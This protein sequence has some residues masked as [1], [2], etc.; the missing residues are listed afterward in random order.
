M[1]RFHHFFLNPVSSLYFGPPGSFNAGEDHVGESW[2]PPPISSF[3]GIIRTKLLQE[4]GIFSPRKKVADLVGT[5]DM[6]P[7]GWQ[8]TGP[9]PAR[10]TPNKQ[11]EIWL[12]VPAFLLP[13]MDRH[14]TSPLFS[15]PCSPEADGTM[16]MDKAMCLDTS[17]KNE[18]TDRFLSLAG[19]PGMAE[20]KPMQ[21]WLSAQNLLWALNPENSQL[22]WE[23]HGCTPYLPPFVF[24]EVKSGL[25]REKETNNSILTITGRAKESMLYFLKRLRFA[26]LSGLTGCL[27]LPDA[28]PTS[29]GAAL[30]HGTLPAGSKGGVVGFEEVKTKDDNWE[31]IINGEHL[32]QAR[33]QD[34]SPKQKRNMV[35]ITLISPGR[36][37][38]FQ[39]ISAKLKLTGP[40]SLKIISLVGHAPIYLGGYNIVKK[41]PRQAIPWYPAGT[42]VLAQLSGGSDG[43]RINYLKAL[44]YSCRLAPEESRPFGYGH[45]V[46]TAPFYSGGLHA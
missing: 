16:L 36:W 34:D 21:G 2:F 40:V 7:Q 11:F 35:W 45:I 12:P 26:P 5:P 15:R 33:G 42:S 19:K 38:T 1:S 27:E 13:P 18:E 25:A 9:F 4:I 22:Q 44:N 6:L 3:Q 41:L 30:H 14:A 10:Y 39:D 20:Q 29:Y 37:E 24:K 17:E 46:V 28:S 23:P 8:M 31:K 32:N 43:E